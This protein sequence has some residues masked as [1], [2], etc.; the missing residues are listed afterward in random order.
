MGERG[1]AGPGGRSAISASADGTFRFWSL[2]QA[3]G[4]QVVDA[5]SSRVTRVAFSPDGRWLATAGDK[6]PVKLRDLRNGG[7][8]VELQGNGLEGNSLLGVDGLDFSPDGRSLAC[9]TQYFTFPNGLIVW[10]LATRRP[11]FAV[12][13]DPGGAKRPSVAGG[14]VSF[15]A[16]SR[17]LACG[18]G[19][20]TICV[21]DVEAG[22]LRHTWEGP[23]WGPMRS[24]AFSLDGRRLASGHLRHMI[25]VRD[26]TSGAVVRT[27]DCG[28]ARMPSFS[29]VCG[30]SFSP[31]DQVLAAVNEGGTVFLWSVADGRL[32]RQL[33]GHTRT[34]AAVTF[35]PDGNR[36]A[37]VG[38]EVK[39]W[40]P[41]SFQELLTLPAPR[42]IGWSL[43]FSPDGQSLAVGGGDFSGPGEAQVWSAGPGANPAR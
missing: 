16:D 13:P 11:R 29:T 17:T 34:T 8:S 19:G 5:R 3:K 38:L 35:S 31:D 2:E 30:L 28:V 1:C 36:L 21:Y 37:S 10:D 20:D 4:P 40:D 15:H 18:G 39:I 26:S 7:V 33:T 24:L 27:L 42:Q 43:A 25:A 12:A 41:K 23:R 22:Q 6:G 14:L 32:I 9:G